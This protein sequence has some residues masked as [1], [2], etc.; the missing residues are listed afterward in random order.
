MSDEKVTQWIGRLAMCSQFALIGI[1][2]PHQIWIMW[3]T[4]SAEGVSIVMNVLIL[5]ACILWWIYGYRKS[6]PAIWAPQIPAV[7]F[8]VVITIMTFYYQF[9]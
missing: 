6:D 5:I 2:K 3:Q 9:C 8:M 7:A 1:G 4:G